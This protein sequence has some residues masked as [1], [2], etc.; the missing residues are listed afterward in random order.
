MLQRVD[1][2]KVVKKKVAISVEKALRQP[3]FMFLFFY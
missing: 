1:T 2:I 3:H